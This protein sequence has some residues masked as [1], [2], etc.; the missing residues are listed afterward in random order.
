[1]L[2]DEKMNSGLNSMPVH[3]GQVIP[4]IDPVDWEGAGDL[5]TEGA[6]ADSLF[7]D[8]LSAVAVIS[9]EPIPALK[10][11]LIS[12]DLSGPLICTVV[13]HACVVT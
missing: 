8:A 1:M 12:W 4:L 13:N 6:L 2:R 11:M 7:Q 5:R 10:L 3:Q 9:P